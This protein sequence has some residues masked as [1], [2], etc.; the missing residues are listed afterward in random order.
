LR[1]TCIFSLFSHDVK[2]LKEWRKTGHD[3]THSSDYK[4]EIFAACLNKGHL[5]YVHIII[6]II[7]KYL[8]ALKWSNSTKKTLKHNKQRLLREEKKQHMCQKLW[9]PFIGSAC[10]W[11]N[12]NFF[13]IV[14]QYRHKVCCLNKESL[15]LQN[16]GG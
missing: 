16:V 14:P 10:C 6:L 3:M 15:V 8:S 12:L 2:V 5:N 4:T 9:E 11:S 1:S 7:T 13:L